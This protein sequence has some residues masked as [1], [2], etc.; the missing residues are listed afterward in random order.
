MTQQISTASA[1]RVTALFEAHA[2]SFLLPAGA[3]FEDLADHLEH[4]CARANGKALAVSVK[5]GA[6]GS[7][8]SD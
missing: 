2:Q 5:V 8:I 6:V 4:M 1:S 7:R 3:T